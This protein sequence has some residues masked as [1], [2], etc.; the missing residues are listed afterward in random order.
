MTSIVSNKTK[1]S[2]ESSKL[3]KNSPKN[4]DIYLIYNYSIDFYNSVFIKGIHSIN[5]NNVRTNFIEIN[6]S[7]YTKNVK[8]NN[9]K[10]QKEENKIIE[11]KEKQK[12]RIVND[13]LIE[14]IL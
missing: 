7:K 14:R 10:K 3:I 12:E 4:E 6:E 9:E 13:Y 11:D 5:K 1:S 2:E 8:I